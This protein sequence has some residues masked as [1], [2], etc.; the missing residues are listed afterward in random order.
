MH[1]YLPWI[2]TALILGGCGDHIDPRA[3]FD[4]AVNPADFPNSRSR[5]PAEE[6]ITV[7]CWEDGRLF[8]SSLS[9]ITLRTDDGLRYAFTTALSPRVLE[10]VDVASVRQAQQVFPAPPLP[11]LPQ[12]RLLPPLQPGATREERRTR[13][14]EEARQ[15]RLRQEYEI[16]RQ[17]YE[18]R[19]LRTG[20]GSSLYRAVQRA[21]MEACTRNYV[22]SP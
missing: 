7:E 15:Q 6:P 19:R 16:R 2:A 12:T 10:A 20:G 11:A 22:G 4:L 5:W 1:K 3:V 13:Q 14:R 9:V 8:R 17:E 21:A 18:I